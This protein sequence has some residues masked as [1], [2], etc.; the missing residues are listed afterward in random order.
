MVKDNPMNTVVVVVVVVVFV[1]VFIF[2]I[3]LGATAGMDLIDFNAS[4]EP[5]R[6]SWQLV[7][8]HL[9]R[10]RDSNYRSKR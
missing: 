2:I 9:L 10:S 3:T 5:R 4:L 1:F 6:N 8:E 7:V